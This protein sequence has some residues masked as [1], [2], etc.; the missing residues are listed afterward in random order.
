MSKKETNIRCQH[1]S[2]GSH[3]PGTL[4]C[5]N[6]GKPLHSKV[7]KKF[8]ICGAVIIVIAGAFTLVV[9]L[10]Q[11]SAPPT[12]EVIG[13]EDSYKVQDKAEEYT[14]NFVL[15]KTESSYHTEAENRE[16]AKFMSQLDTGD[17]AVIIGTYNQKDLVQQEI[18]RIKTKYPELFISYLSS[19]IYDQYCK[20]YGEGKFFDGRYW[21]IY[22]GEFYSKDSANLLKEKAI[23]ELEI[24][25]D[26]FVRSVLTGDSEYTAHKQEENAGWIF[27]G[28]YDRNRNKIFG[29]IE[30]YPR[31][32]TEYEF[33]R[34]DRVYNIRKSPP[35]TVRTYYNDLKRDDIIGRI[36]E[37]DRFLIKEIREFLVDKNQIKIWA[38][39]KKRD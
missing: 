5:P 2:E 33:V 6:T 37:G 26:A 13:I 8:V 10:N 23:K 18:E 9:A 29:N 34:K 38:E 27:I 15:K 28:A 4:F 11:D 1:C 14:G 32:E 24:P 39:I 16:L 35:R 7:N 36:R 17:Y 20:D 25:D 12:G 31:I 3:P 22:I 30:G 19:E 21:R